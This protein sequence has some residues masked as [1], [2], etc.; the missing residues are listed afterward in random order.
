RRMKLE[1]A[2]TEAS[3][4]IAEEERERPWPR[5][6]VL[7]LAVILGYANSLRVPFLL[8]DPRPTDVISLSRRPLMWSSFALNRAFGA[9]ILWQYHAFNALVH[10][11]SGLALYG[12]LRRGCALAAPALAARTRDRLPF[13]T[14]LLWLVHPLE[15]AAITYIS[16]RGEAMASF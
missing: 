3:A 12:V 8:D 5:V 7:S 15:T 14:S 6:L 16:Q 9:E 11:F 2:S 10:L 4:P 13:A 1:A